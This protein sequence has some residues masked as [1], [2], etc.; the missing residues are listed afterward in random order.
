MG[1]TFLA[2]GI[3]GALCHGLVWSLWSPFMRALMPPEVEETEVPPLRP[4]RTGSQHIPGGRGYRCDII[5][6]GL[7]FKGDGL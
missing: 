1:A 6:S 4:N 5:E 7:F 2:A 3:V